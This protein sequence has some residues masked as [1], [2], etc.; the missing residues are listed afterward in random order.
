MPHYF[1]LGLLPKKRHV[2]FRRPDGV[3]YSEELFGTEGFVG[4]SSTMYHINPPTQV[5]G[6]KT[7]YSTKA[8]F[9]EVEVMRMRHVKS[10][11]GMN[12]FVPP[13][14]MASGIGQGVTPHGDTIDGRVVLFGNSDVEMA[15]CNPTS[16]ME[17]YY[18]NGQG[19]ECIFVHYGSGVC[20][21]MM[22]ALRFGPKDYIVIPKGV[23]YQMTWDDAEMSAEERFLASLN[24]GGKKA[25]A[26][27]PAKASKNAPAWRPAGAPDNWTVQQ[28]PLGKYLLIETMNGS[29]IGPPP[30]YV[31]KATGQFLE[32]APYCER[33]LRLPEHDL[34]AGRPMYIEGEAGYGEFEVR[35]KARDCMHSYMFHYH[36]LDIVGWDGCYYPYI[37]NIND[38]APITGKLHMPPPIHQTFEAHNF[39]ICSFCPRMLDY[40]P[41]AIKVPYNHS[42][43]DSDEVLYYVE[44]NF[45][46]RKGIE[47]GSLTLHP[48][49]I[50]HGPHPGT[51]E[52][53]MQHAFTGE[54]AVMCDTFRPL[55]PTKAA[56]ELED[57]KYPASWEGEHFPRLT[58]G[59]EVGGNFRAEKA[60]GSRVKA[61][62]GDLLDIYTNQNA[63]PEPLKRLGQPSAPTPTRNVWAPNGAA[64][65][66]SNGVKNG[67]T[68]GIGQANGH[69]NGKSNGAA[70]SKPAASAAKRSPAPVTGGGGGGGGGKKRK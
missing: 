14:K 22:G 12:G 39:V 28:M 65:P 9:V 67:T 16:Q 18:K 7:L 27:K 31:S 59:Q 51:I 1:R 40:H 62:F 61:K 32:H 4:P 25:K 26:K 29:H 49:G 46:S 66:A 58:S 8:E 60:K 63:I 20:H 45:G 13:E 36:P 56:V 15:I 10:G 34:A 2:Q 52:A 50:P 55:F 64:A 37:F 23:I 53:S 17:Y 30:R 43:I 41:D 21:T 6:W 70:R 42:N 48:Q 69:A 57:M 68:N 35:V 19:D 54:L 24:S 33:D 47:V 5:Y 38:F 44:G 3:L 11:H